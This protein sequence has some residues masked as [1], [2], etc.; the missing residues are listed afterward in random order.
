MSRSRDELVI[1]NAIEAALGAEPDLLLLRNVVTSPEI[2]DDEG[3]VH[4]FPVGL[5]TGSPDLVA[6]LRRELIVAVCD[7]P[8]MVGEHHDASGVVISRTVYH[9]CRPL[10]VGQWFCLEVKRPGKTASPSQEKCHAQWRSFGAFVAV[11]DS[12]EG[13]REALARARRG[14]A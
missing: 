2:V 11:V 14:E 1:Q 5:G 13:A 9:A 6:H 8:A 4:K 3:N 12:V 7:T 10:V